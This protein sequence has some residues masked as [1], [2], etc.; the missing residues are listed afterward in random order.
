[1]LPRWPMGTGA[2]DQPTPSP[3]GIRQQVI[4]LAGTR[5]A[6]LNQTHF[7]DLLEEREGVIL[8]RSTVR[9]ILGGRPGVGTPP[10]APDPRA[11]ASVE[12]AS[13]GRVLVQI[14]GSHHD[15]LGGRGPVMALLLAVDDATGTVPWSLFRYQEDTYGYFLLLQGILGAA[16]GFPWRCTVTATPSSSLRPPPG[17][18]WR[19]MWPETTASRN[20]AGRWGNL[21]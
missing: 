18:R 6:G 5:Y 16:G 3:E 9:N 11:I 7:T 1:M 4:R 14:D 12:S 13:P 20:S 17:A 8:A 19:T 21:G 2:V 15:W 10:A